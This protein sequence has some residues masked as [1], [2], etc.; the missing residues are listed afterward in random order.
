MRYMDH[1]V[2]R[3]P[4]KYSGLRFVDLVE[5]NY[6]KL[7]FWKVFWE[8]SSAFFPIKYLRLDRLNFNPT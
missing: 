5:A 4:P 2:F 7:P 6:K 3:L 8:K 1:G